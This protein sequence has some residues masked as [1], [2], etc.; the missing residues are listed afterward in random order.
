MCDVN[1]KT[2]KQ[3]NKKKEII[4][5]RRNPLKERHN[6]RRTAGCPGNICLRN[7]ARSGVC[8]TRSAPPPG[9]NRFPQPNEMREPKGCE[10]KAS[11]PDALQLSNDFRTSF[12]F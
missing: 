7:I 10:W 11:G 4:A 9:H 5:T 8:K 12:H 3:L 2:E 1:E 6:S